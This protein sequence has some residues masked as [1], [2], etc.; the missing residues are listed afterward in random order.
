MSLLE[1][2]EQARKLEFEL[3]ILTAHL[4]D[5]NRENI[6][7]TAQQLQKDDYI[8]TKTDLEKLLKISKEKKILLEE[9]LA[10]ATLNLEDSQT[11]SKN[12]INLILQEI[13]EILAEIEEVDKKYKIEQNTNNELKNS[14]NDLKIKLSNAQELKQKVQV[15][16][17]AYKAESNKRDERILF[18]YIIIIIYY[19]NHFLLLKLLLEWQL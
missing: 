6:V 2:Q 18:V 5:V 15:T 17:E 4:G 9:R 8:K 14:V 7:L 10:Q 13:Q 1:K 12:E 11:T 3:N 16:I 19:K